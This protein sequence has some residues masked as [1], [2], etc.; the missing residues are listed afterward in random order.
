MCMLNVVR[1]Q[2]SGTVWNKSHITIYLF[3]SI[4]KVLV[5]AQLSRLASRLS[6]QWTLRPLGKARWPAA[7]A[8][9]R[10]QSLMWTLLKTKTAH[11][12]SSTRRRCLASMSSA[13][14]L[15]ANTSLTVPSKSRWVILTSSYA[16]E[17][18]WVAVLFYCL[19]F[20]TRETYKFT[21]K[22]KL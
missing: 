13:F 9:P 22:L 15:E 21:Q 10:G 14:A 3:F 6:S 18:G 11:L 20:G 2:G 19:V 5:S 17:V 12:T 4:L 16:E 8:R 7:C 1:V